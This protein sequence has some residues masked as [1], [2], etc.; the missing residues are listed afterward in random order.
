VQVQVSKLDYNTLSASLA[1]RCKS[2]YKHP[3]R[4]GASQLDYTFDYK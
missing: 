3:W 4:A 2:V 1:C